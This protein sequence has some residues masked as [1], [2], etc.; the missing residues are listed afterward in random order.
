MARARRILLPIG[1]HLN[2]DAVYMVQ[3]EQTEGTV[4]VVSKAAKRFAPAP[5]KARP[6][7]GIPIPASKF[8]SGA[9]AN[10]LAA[11]ETTDT[12]PSVCSN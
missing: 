2:A 6:V 10:R 8:A 5:V 9:G 3:F 4:S 12:V 11:F 1:I 7:W